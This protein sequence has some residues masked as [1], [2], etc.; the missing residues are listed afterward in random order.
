[1]GRLLLIP[2]IAVLLAGCDDPG[3]GS[4][5]RAHGDLACA[6]C[7]LGPQGE[8]GRATV[9]ASSCAGSGCHEGGGPA[10][11]SVAT[12]TF[13][14]RDHGAESEIEPTCAGCHTHEEGA[15]PLRA[16]VDACALCHVGDVTG[17]AAEDCR[18]CHQQPD[19]TQLT[20]Q[21]VAVS[22][23]QLPW[24]EIGCVRCH[25]DVAD[26]EVGV[27]GESCRQCH[28]SM[29]ALNQAAV[30]RDL[31]PIHDG[32]SCTSCH[33]EGTHRL[34]AMSSVVD[35][36]CSDC[37]VEV[38]EIRVAQGAGVANSACA[39][40]H[41][42]VHAAQQRLILGVRPDGGATPS[43]KFLAGITCRSCHL[44]SEGGPSSPSRPIRGTAAA[45][46]GCHE[47]EYSRVLDW[48]IEGIRSRL[49]A[50]TQYVA[51][52]ES[53]LGTPSDSAAALLG[54]AREM[55]E[56]VRA[57]G[58]QHNLELSDR[59]MREAVDRARGAYRVAGRTPPPAPD[60]GR[61]PH[62]GL[63]SYCHYR[64]DEPWN[65]EVMPADFHQSLVGR[66]R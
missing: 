54:T 32:V 10:E 57:A 12:V 42:G 63:C 53:E 40:C 66:G 39:E 21:G 43:T 1:M 30:G 26:P 6:A 60:M 64:P 15:D 13:P 27:S 7:H 19:H 56:L 37:H 8:R 52:A 46:A 28:E 62:T 3:S 61:V 35:L 17:A 22:H 47:Q 2:L 50:S 16:S 58:G 51:R 44:S 45:C 11:V 18:L 9:P 5:E 4:G 23:S 48:W 20:S 34:Q 55:V 14:H 31:H 25:Y 41:R 36:V 49:A 59:L 38:H 29:D 33:A 65:F 24:I